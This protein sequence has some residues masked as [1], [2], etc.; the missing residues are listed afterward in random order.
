MK[1]DKIFQI[2]YADI[3]PSTK[4]VDNCKKNPKKSLTTKVGKHILSEYFILT[5]L[6]HLIMQK[7]IIAYITE[8]IIRKY[9][10]ILLEN[11]IKK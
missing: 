11:M 3:E 1:S 10:V 6:G 4:K 9:F 2:I 8:K 5:L 7:I